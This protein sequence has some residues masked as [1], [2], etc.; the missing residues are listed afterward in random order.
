[1]AGA[2]VELLEENGFEIVGPA[3]DGPWAIAL[4]EETRPAIALLDYRMPRLGGVE[5]VSR[6]HEAASGRPILLSGT[7]RS[8]GGLRSVP[9][10]CAPTCA[11]RR[12]ASG[13]RRRRR[14]WRQRS[15]GA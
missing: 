10:P 8:A 9:R 12:N 13:P 6:L 2:L 14:P 1:M 7:R 5:L 3:P 4:A 11:G 15:A